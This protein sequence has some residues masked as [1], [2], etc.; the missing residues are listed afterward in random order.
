MRWALLQAALPS[1]A[2]AHHAPGAGGGAAP[3]SRKA[4][5]RHRLGRLRFRWSRKRKAN[6]GGQAI[7]KKGGVDAAVL[8]QSR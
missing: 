6:W 3:N 5:A 7:A 1:R 2:F 8:I 4:R